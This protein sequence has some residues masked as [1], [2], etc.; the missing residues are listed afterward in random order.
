[1]NWASSV[2]KAKEPPGGELPSGLGEQC[3]A[4]SGSLKGNG[5]QGAILGGICVGRQGPGKA[6]LGRIRRVAVVTASAVLVAR[7]LGNHIWAA[8]RRVAVVT[9]SAVLV[10][11]GLGKHIWAVSGRLAVFAG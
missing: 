8:S 5:F 7:G 1:M 10:A 4:N 6:Y 11:G 2:G 9:A 3:L